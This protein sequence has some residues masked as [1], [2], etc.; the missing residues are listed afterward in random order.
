MNKKLKILLLEDLPS[1]VDLICKILK[2][3]K[4]DFINLAVETADKFRNALKEFS[5]DIILSDHSLP[6]F[7]SYN[8]LDILHKTGLKIPFI[9][10]TATISEEFAVDILKAGADDYILKDR[11]ERLPA[12]VS[13][14]LEKFRLQHEREKFLDELIKKEKHYRA[15][16]DNSAD[17]VV[18]LNAEGQPTYISPAVKRILG[19]TEDE[20]FQMDLFSISHPD[21]ISGLAN[22]MDMVLANPGVAMKGH[23]GR[24]L[25]KDGSWRWLEATVTN[26]LHDPAINGIVDNFRDITERRLAEEKVMQLNRLLAFLSQINKTIVHS[27]DE[28]TIF[29]ETCRIAI[30]TGKFKGAWIGLL[31]GPNKRIQ[32]VEKS[33]VLPEDVA[34]RV[35]LS[36][37]QKG[38]QYKV[39][40]TGAYFIC[41]NIAEDPQIG[42]WSIFSPEDGYRSMM[43][44]PIRK[45][46]NT[47][48]TLNLY[49]AEV[50]FFTAAE[51]ELLEEATADISFSLDFLLASKNVKHKEVRL[52]Q[53]QAIAHLGSW[54]VDLATGIITWSEEALRIHGLAPGESSQSYESWLS[55]VH[56]EDLD[57]VMK[58]RKE[59]EATLNDSSFFHR[60]VRK[61]GTVKSVFSTAQFEFDHSGKPI[62]LYG[63]THDMTELIEAEEELRKSESNLQAIFENTSEGFI[64]IDRNG[65]VKLF[66]S[67]ARE[68]M[69]RTVGRHLKVGHS[70]VSLLPTTRTEDYKLFFSKVLA[71]ESIN[72]D[73]SYEVIPGKIV[74]INFVINPVYN[75]GLID[76]VCITVADI[77]KRKQT[78]DFLAQ[79]E[80]RYRQIVETAQEGIWLMDE[81]NKTTFVNTKMCDI[82][83]YSKEEMLGKENFYF[84]DDAHKQQALSM[85]DRKI[86]VNADMQ[87]ITKSGKSIWTN[88][89]ANPVFNDAGNYQGTLA[90]VSD[91]TEKKNLE[92]LLNKATTMARI[93]SWEAD[94]ANNK[95]YWSTI[96]KEIHEVSSDFVP[97]L[98]KGLDF[99]K[100][101]KNKEII[102]QAVQEAIE[103][104]KPWDLELQIVTAKGKERWVQAIGETEF[105]DGKCTKLFGSFQDIHI[106]KNAEMEVLKAYEE[107]NVILESIGDG[108]FAVDK[109]WIVTYWN[110]EAE[111]MLQTP[112]NK[113]LG[114]Y[115]WDVFSDSTDSESYRKYHQ[116]IESNE[117]IVFEDHYPPLGRWYEISAYPS[118]N[119]L[120]VYFKDITERKQSELALKELNDNLSKQATELA[121]T[122]KELED[123]AY[124]ASHDL[125]EPLRMVTSFL[126]QLEKKYSDLIDEKGKTYIHFAVDGPR[127]CGKLSLTC[128]S[129]QEWAILWKKS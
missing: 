78:E 4:L 95:L 24:M 124:A 20:I 54:E 51:I 87:F 12:A 111:K 112:K 50:N 79:S 86:K 7:N 55:F 13:N 28:H 119:G 80:L 40:T 23:T 122:N 64:L 98:E 110:K 65:F 82:L 47:I 67:K 121:I 91:I 100:A 73:R 58:V 15:L 115:L 42:K 84:V 77:T 43:I 41:N 9:L 75:A 63:I 125:Q 21:D 19:Y 35:S 97:D 88:L 52:H 56:P 116:A 94:L 3:G 59:A 44:L 113:I 33:G 74:W 45:S 107:K 29:K 90:M 104:N 48:G 72:Y 81:N 62:Y 96:T 30:E 36:Y 6:S 22:T 18:I 103:N 106:A 85:M 71:G 61:D 2:K 93:G 31:D 127:E 10:I 117:V 99:Y 69:M 34:A 120:S 114:K 14:A 1:D 123:F 126:S 89:S 66:N 25:H 39:L 83:G 129:F 16:V 109:N 70:L 37:Q 68:Y 128:W 11:L 17:G 46:G 49:S 105:V 102:T 27:V 60:I 26:L 101:G 57:R 76:G 118:E 38:P 53:A 5:P 108:F 32:L 92:E 8:A